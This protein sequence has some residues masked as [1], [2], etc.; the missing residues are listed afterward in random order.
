[1]KSR[2]T[3]EP[4]DVMVAVG[5]FATVLGISVFFLATE[6]GL[7]TAPSSEP[8]TVQTGN[9]DPMQAMQ[10]VQPAL[11][12]AI[13]DSTLLERRYREE[14]MEVA[15][16]LNQAIYISQRFSNGTAT[17]FEAIQDRA[18]S[19]EADHQARVQYVMGR[20][21]ANFTKQGV[22]SGTVSPDTY[23]NEHNRYLINVAEDLG[24]RMDRDF[25]ANWQPNL[26]WSIV[27]ASRDHSQA[28]QRIQERMGKS[29]VSVTKVQHRYETTSANLQEQLA[30]TA[31]ASIRTER[32]ADL[33]RT[34]ALADR[35]G[36]ETTVVSSQKSWPDIPFEA[37]I[38]A[39]VALVAL[40]MAGLAM[41]SH[42]PE[43]GVRSEATDEPGFE[44]YRKTA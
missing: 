44:R 13:V 12:Q 27:Q 7:G 3:I 1:M 29:V 19:A 4:V 42:R 38:G 35:I 5:L 6:G 16:E 10:W 17:H 15:G 40:F 23:S 33:F 37:I 24:A 43:I 30:G 25:S 18:T 14:A 39:S 9:V 36:A 26:G 11:G 8:Q 41:P 2:R 20:T 22:R 28:A 21:I 32:Q 34:L 31:I